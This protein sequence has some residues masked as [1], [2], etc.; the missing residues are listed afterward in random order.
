MKNDEP[1][2]DCGLRIENAERKGH[3]AERWRFWNLEFGF[4]IEVIAD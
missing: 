1:I 2:A 3:S 4:W